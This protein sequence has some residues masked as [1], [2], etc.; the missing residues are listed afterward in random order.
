MSATASDTPTVRGASVTVAPHLAVHGF[1]GLADLREALDADL[2]PF[3]WRRA[4]LETMTLREALLRRWWSPAVFFPYAIR[5]R[6]ISVRLNKRVL[7]EIDQREIEVRATVLDWDRPKI[8]DKKSKWENDQ[9]FEESAAK[10]IEAADKLGPLKH[11]STLYQTR[12][13]LRLIYEFL[14]PVTPMEADQITEGAIDQF[15]TQS[16]EFDRACVPWNHA[17]KLP[18]VLH[19]GDPAPANP[20]IKFND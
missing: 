12:H 17:F 4:T 1:D 13:G 19:E 6:N 11:W 18:R 16:W 15:A 5:R 2:D 8:D 9:E 10:L 3:R 20:I 7:G 14:K